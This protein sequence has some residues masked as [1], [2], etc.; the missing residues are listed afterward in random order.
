MLRLSRGR[1][2]SS[3]GF[4][5]I[6][7]LVVIAIIAILAA[8][9]FPVFA[10]ARSRAQMT[11]CS[12]NLNQFG[13]GFAMYESDYPDF[14][15]P[16]AMTDLWA[17]DFYGKDWVSMVNP[18]LKAL[19]KSTTWSLDEN[20]FCP[21]APKLPAT[22]KDLRRPYG[23]NYYYLGYHNPPT[24]KLV[25][26]SR[27]KFP[28]Q[29]IRICEVWNF[30]DNPPT[31]QGSLYIYPPTSGVGN[32]SANWAY[33]PG[34]HSGKGANAPAR[35]K[36]QNNILWFDGHI[37]ALTGDKI[38]YARGGTT[39]DNAYFELDPVKGKP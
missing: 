20:L 31:G 14:A 35:L 6:E 2:R 15:M 38:V 3:A 18:Y 11:T 16:G 5:L 19:A 13:K 36:G 12:S 9:L 29:T 23:Y 25:P 26:I 37:S 8:I 30:K 28:T 21:V 39:P 32:P 34:F 10:K 4:T 17:T 1:I 33:P 24:A 22:M 7:L 27:V